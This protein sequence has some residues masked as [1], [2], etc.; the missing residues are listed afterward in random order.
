MTLRVLIRLTGFTY[1]RNLIAGEYALTR[2]L[3][4]LAYERELVNARRDLAS[5]C[6]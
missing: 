4:R 2:L 3:W 5:T 6:R 1:A